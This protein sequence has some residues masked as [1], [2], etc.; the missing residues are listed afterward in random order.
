MEEMGK[1]GTVDGAAEKVSRAQ[2]EYES[3][4]AAPDSLR[5]EN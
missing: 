2:A 3:V 1:A 5:E 4:K